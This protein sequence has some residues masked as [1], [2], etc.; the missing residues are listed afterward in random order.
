M[1][2]S[3]IWISKYI[4]R[5]THYY[6]YTHHSVDHE[7]IFY[8]KPVQFPLER[9]PGRPISHQYFLNYSKTE[10]FCAKNGV[11]RKLRTNRLPEVVRFFLEPQR[12]RMLHG[13][14]INQ[15]IDQI[16]WFREVWNPWD[17]NLVTYSTIT[18]SW[19][20]QTNPQPR[21]PG[22][23]RLHE[24]L[25]KPYRFLLIDWSLFLRF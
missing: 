3:S 16:D 8:K 24:K 13:N 11:L 5:Y 9:A 25:M 19:L 7:N 17:V 10:I 2:A 23:N 14:K 6:L 20:L 18:C 22:K 21:N 12:F 15:V 4:E 1:Y